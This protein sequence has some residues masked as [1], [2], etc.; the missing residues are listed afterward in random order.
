MKALAPLSLMM[1]PLSR[2]CVAMCALFLLVTSAVSTASVGA[3]QSSNIR[4]ETYQFKPNGQVRVENKRGGT[5]IEVWDDW[6][7]Q[8]VAEK[9]SGKPLDPGDLALMAAENSL[10]IQCR[11]AGAADRVD[12]EVFVPRRSHLELVGGSFPVD[13]NGSLGSA[14]VETTT[15]NIA[16]RLP[17]SDSARVA[18]HSER[19]I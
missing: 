8:I 16:Y 19:G 6:S 17:V 11:D 2:W 9:K 13:I 1:A 10:L 7:V 3:A 15:G 14:V 4:M 5:R 12:V 18:M